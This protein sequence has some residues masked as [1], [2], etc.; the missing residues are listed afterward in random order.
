M[1]AGLGAAAVAAVVLLSPAAYAIQGQTQ[2]S[3][4]RVSVGEPFNVQLSVSFEGGSSASP[5][6]AGLPLPP[7]MSA[8]GPS[9]S[10]G[11]NLV[12]NNG[13]VTRTTTVTL[14]WQVVA[15]RVGSF[16]VGPPN[17]AF[18]TQRVEGQPVQI[19][20][21]AAN[22]RRAQAGRPRGL[23]P[24]FPFDFA[25]PLGGM[26]FPRGLFDDDPAQAQPE[27]PRYPDELR[28]DKAPDPVAFLRVTATPKQVV[29]GQQVTLKVLAYGGRGL[30]NF[31]STK[32]ATAV[33]FITLR[34]NAR[35]DAEFYRVPVGDAQFVALKLRELALFPLHAGKQRVGNFKMGFAGRGYPQDQAGKFPYRESNWVDIEV[36]EPPLRGRPPG[37]KVGDVGDYTLSANVEPRQIAAGDSV[38]VVATLSGVGNVPFKVQNPEGHGVEWPE[39]SLSEKIDSRNG[40]VQGSRTFSYVVRVTEPGMIDLGEVTLPYYNPESHAYA[41][42]RAKLGVVEVKPNPKAPSASVEQQPTDRLAGILTPRNALG[43]PAGARAPLSD[44]GGFWAALLLAPFTVVFAGGALNAAARLKEKL[45]ARGTSLSAQLE[46]ALSDARELGKRDTAGSVAAVERAVFLAIELKLGLKAR[47]ILKS[48]LR[49]TLIARG[50]SEAPAGGLAQLLEDCDT[51]RFVG[52]ASGVEPDDLAQRAAKHCAALRDDKLSVQ[53]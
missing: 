32:E 14:T 31:E 26:T 25:S 12:D 16:K 1:R 42:A 17:M 49:A 45:R 15:S 29:V 20:V 6:A 13:R 44:R 24:G 4:R 10:S 19:E 22:A 52:S 8:S 27:E 37:Y 7:G 46:H 21:V 40:V 48:E 47:A 28:V 11:W 9:S 39:P 34:D 38:S 23:P 18:D 30:F 5:T 36:T 33:D 43:A 2:V 53:S 35:T 51:L 3:S 50:V 41:T